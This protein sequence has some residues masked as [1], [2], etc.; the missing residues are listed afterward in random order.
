[1]TFKPDYLARVLPPSP[2]PGNK[3]VLIHFLSQHVCLSI[4]ETESKEGQVR[5]RMF[6]AAVT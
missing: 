2:L 1:M 4:F 3:K 6:I 5:R